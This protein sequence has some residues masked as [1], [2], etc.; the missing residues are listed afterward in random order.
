MKKAMRYVL[1]GAFWLAVWW[2]AAAIVHMNLLLPG[3]GDTVRA[4]LPMVQTA[5]F[6]KSVGMTFLRVALS[7][8]LSVL[9]G[10]LLA[11][12]CHHFRWLDALMAPLRSV[13]RATPVSSFIFLVL[14]WVQKGKV[15]VLISFLA[16]LPVV[17][18][19]MQSGLDAI[20]PQLL[21]MTRMYGFSRWKRMRC[22]YVPALRPSF[23]AACITGLGFA[24]KAGIA[25]E[26]I[27]TPAL[28]VGGKLYD[29]KVYGERAELFAW[30]LTVVILSMALEALLKRAVQREKGAKA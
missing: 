27:A 25:A 30:T 9:A 29:A 5:A 23:S 18:T 21:E 16:V 26:V 17:W 7:W 19:D 13:I 2:A 8:A 10:S 4:L 3:P 11:A 28:S 1:I 14:L 15:P 6:W 24:W 12:A 20:D 22:L